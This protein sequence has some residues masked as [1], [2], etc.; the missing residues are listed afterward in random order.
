MMWKTSFNFPLNFRD[1]FKNGMLKHFLPTNPFLLSRGQHL[2]NNIDRFLTYANLMRNLDFIPQ[3][4]LAQFLG[5]IAI[6][7]HVAKEYLVI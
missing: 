6:K 5:R 7:R 3:Y 2:E 1:L 4:L